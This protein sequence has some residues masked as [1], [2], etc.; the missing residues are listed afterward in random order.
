MNKNK[1]LTAFAVTML[2]SCAGFAMDS[3]DEADIGLSSSSSAGALVTPMKEISSLTL[4][5]HTY[6]VTPDTKTTVESMV[7]KTPAIEQ[8]VKSSFANKA[9]PE[10]QRGRAVAAAIQHEK[11]LRDANMDL[12]HAIASGKD[13]EI[14]S[15]ATKKKA[16]AS[17]EKHKKHSA[18]QAKDVTILTSKLTQLELDLEG[19]KSEVIRLGSE[20]SQLQSQIENDQSEKESLTS[21]LDALTSTYN[22]LKEDADFDKDDLAIR[23][24][25]IEVLA[26][27]LRQKTGRII[28]L[29]NNLSEVELAKEKAEIYMSALRSSAVPS[30]AAYEEKEFEEGLSGNEEEDGSGNDE[31][32]GSDNGENSHKPRDFNLEDD[33]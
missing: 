5:E 3:G 4:G 32:D 33:A 25:Q 2:G 15:N 10:R 18:K 23:A 20:K 31:E 24:Q 19:S 28:E 9:M 27:L 30:A 6:S 13:K 7:V 8:K 11:T 1:F 22:E 29:Q 12:A 17:A 21:R 26:S 14:K 16:F